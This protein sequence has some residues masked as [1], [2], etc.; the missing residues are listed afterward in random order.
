METGDATVVRRASAAV[1]NIA[2]WKMRASTQP[3]Q[4]PRV[5]SRKWWKFRV[6]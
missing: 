3:D 1:V 2:E 6:V 5:P 4:P